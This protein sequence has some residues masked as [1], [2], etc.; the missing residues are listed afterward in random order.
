MTT[1][2][3]QI[4]M[5]MALNGIVEISTMSTQSLNLAAGDIDCKDCT[6]KWVML[7]RDMNSLAVRKLCLPQLV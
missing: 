7:W 3:W 6:L 2:R 1:E 4:N 5:R